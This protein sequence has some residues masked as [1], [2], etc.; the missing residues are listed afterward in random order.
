MAAGKYRNKIIIESPS[1]SE[2]NAFNEPTEHA[3]EN[4]EYVTT[5]WA[6]IMPMS[7]QE[8]FV[9]QQI[10]PQ[11]THKVRLRYMPGITS[12]MRICYG[13]RILYIESVINKGE[14]NIELELNCKERP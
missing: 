4:W 1:V 7:G 6:Q 3:K 11:L 14:K 12:D 13:Q 9:A 8:L 5:A 10:Q 2:R